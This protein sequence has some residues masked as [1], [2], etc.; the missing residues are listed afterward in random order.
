MASDF[1]NK[2]IDK[3]KKL[4]Q[5]WMNKD[6]FEWF[7][8]KEKD[9]RYYYLFVKIKDQIEN[10]NNLFELSNKLIGIIEVNKNDKIYID[11]KNT[12]NEKLKTDYKNL[13]DKEIPDYETKILKGGGGYY[14]FIKKIIIYSNA[15]K[16]FKHEIQNFYFTFYNL[17][18]NTHS[19]RSIMMSIYHI[20]NDNNLTNLV[21]LIKGLEGFK[22]DNDIK[23][24]EYFD[25]KGI[26]YKKEKSAVNQIR[27]YY[28]RKYNSNTN[29][30]YPDDE[31][32]SF[33]VNLNPFL[34]TL[35]YLNPNKMFIYNRKAL[36]KYGWLQNR[37]IDKKCEIET[38]DDLYIIF[39]NILKN[40][41]YIKDEFKPI[42]DKEKDLMV[43]YNLFGNNETTKDFIKKMELDQFA[44]YVTEKLEGT[45]LLKPILEYQKQIV[46]Q[47]PPGTGKTWNAKQFLKDK[48]K[49]EADLNDLRF[50]ENKPKKDINK[51]I[52]DGEKPFLW[53]IIQFHPSYSYEDFVYGYKFDDTNKGYKPEPKI[54]YKICKAAKEN[55]KYDYFLIIDEINR[56]DISKIFG[57]LIYALEKDKRDEP[58]KLQSG[59]SL[60]IPDNLY[61][62]GTMNTADRSIAI[63]DYALRRRFSFID[64]KPDFTDLNDQCDD[65]IVKI[66]S[67][68]ENINN[69]LLQNNSSGYMIG[70]SYFMFEKEEN[71]DI[72]K[73]KIYLNLKYQ[74]LPIL[75]EYIQEGL[76]KEEDI[77]KLKDLI[78]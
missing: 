14:N 21:N 78:L 5:S 62:I 38:I 48:L 61:I 18:S 10:W 39:D 13:F 60:T 2:I 8:L 51:I 34:E 37:K 47:G 33:I 53:D 41:Y 15:N 12:D 69:I 57:E 27:V 64:L 17:I 32:T 54:F 50:D 63:V 56:G 75:E 23:V 20:F 40:N 70:H 73:E 9:K 19:S 76:V 29:D 43:K 65:E 4:H 42:F 28:K 46:L 66:I 25:K 36:E 30:F 49:N 31:Q 44:Q 6:R 58:I 11:I 52:N 7:N 72:I 67:E 3:V 26:I 24:K 77:E 71:E 22:N 1:D 55:N 68:I 35:F 16:E 59:E 45:F 74:V